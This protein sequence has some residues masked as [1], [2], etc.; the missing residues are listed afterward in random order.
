MRICLA[1]QQTP[2]EALEVGH[3]DFLRLGGPHLKEDATD[4]WLSI[5]IRARQRTRFTATSFLSSL[6][7]IDRPI[8][9]AG[10]RAGST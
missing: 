4:L 2:T 3:L 9:R 7:E 1:G 6:V 10:Q 5:T 8:Y